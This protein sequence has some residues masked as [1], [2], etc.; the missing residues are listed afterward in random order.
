MNS[1]E[2]SFLFSYEFRGET[3]QVEIPAESA[4]EAQMRLAKM[5]S[6][7]LDG[8][9]K[10]AIPVAVRPTQRLMRFLGVRRS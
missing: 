7:Q 10:M 4:A 2:R 6:A 1:V 8:E 9:A 5:A 3:F